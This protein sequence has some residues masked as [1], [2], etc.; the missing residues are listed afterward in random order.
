MALSLAPLEMASVM[1]Q[2]KAAEVLMAAH[3]FLKT[4]EN[5]RPL[6]Q[7]AH[8]ITMVK[9]WAVLMYLEF[10]NVTVIMLLHTEKHAR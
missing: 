5:L 8:F 9:Q 2:N 1:F 7:K 4:V 10:W 6:K 3:V